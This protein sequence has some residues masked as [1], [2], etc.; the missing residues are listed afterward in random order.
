MGWQANYGK[1][2]LLSRLEKLCQDTSFFEPI[3]IKAGYDA[4]Q[5]D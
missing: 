1:F 4:G 2:G 5:N 3:V